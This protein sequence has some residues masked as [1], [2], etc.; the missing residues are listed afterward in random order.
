MRGD[1][2]KPN[3]L[4]HIYGFGRIVRWGRAADPTI[5]RP[6]AEEHGRAERALAYLRVRANCG[7]WCMWQTPLQAILRRK[8]LV[9]HNESKHIEGL[10]R[11]V[12]G[13]ARQAPRF[14]D[15]RRKNV[16]AQNERLH[17]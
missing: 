12:G 10:A 17:I 9:K 7:T 3:E 14:A 2:V 1:L 5:C 13:G 8:E 15:P 11:I 16:V 6:T 4:K